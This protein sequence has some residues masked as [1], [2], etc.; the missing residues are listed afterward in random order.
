MQYD[1]HAIEPAILKRWQAEG[2]YAKVKAKTQ[3][4]KPFYFLD[5][6]PYA[7]GKVH[8][9]TAWNKSLKDAVLRYK[10]MQGFN[11]WDR[12]GY[13]MHGLP[14]ENAAMKKLGLKDN[15]DI[16]KL[17]INTFLEECRKFAIENMH[18]MNE[19]FMRLGVWMDFENAYQ[20][21]TKEFMEAEWWLIKQAHEKGR[22]YEGL[23]TMTWCANAESSL[24]KHELEYKT[25]TDESI[26]VKF[27]IADTDNEYL[28][29][30]TTTPW[31][32]PF[33]LA[34][35]VNPEVEY[36]KA[37]VD[38]E[39]WIVASPLAGVFIQ[40][41]ANKK[42]TIKETFTGDK[43]EGV[44]YIHPF[45]DVLKEEYDAIGEHAKK[46]HTILLS[47]EYVDT[48]AGSGL[49]HCAPGC[50]PEDYE[51]GHRNGLPAYNTIDTKGVFPDSMHEF[52]GLKAKKD[53]KKFIEALE[54]RGALV[55]TTDVEHEYPHDWRYH[56]PVIF[57][58]T[59]QWFFKVEDLKEQMVKANDGITWVPQAAYNAFDSWLKN[60]RDNSISKQ[61]YWGTPLPVWRNEDNPDD[62]IVIGS[63]KELE[64]LSGKKVDDLHISTV[65]T[66]T[67]TKDGKNYKRIPDVLDVWVDAGTVSWN[68][69]DYPQ[70]TDLFENLFPADFILEGKDQIRGWF[71][72]LMVASTLAFD[73]P[74]F[75]NVYMHGFINDAQGRKMSKSLG[76]YI[77]PQ[78]VIDKYGADTFRYYMI[79]AANPG[80]DC[81]YNMDDVDLKHR[82][83]FVFWNIQNFIIQMAQQLDVDLSAIKP[84]DIGD[85]ERYILSLLHATIRDATAAF[86]AYHINEIPGMIERLLLGLSR[87][88]IQLIREKASSGT[89]QEQETVLAT[90]YTVFTQAIT[91]FAPI[92]PFVSEQMHENLRSVSMAL[93]ESIH[94]E[95][96]PTH[97][98]A[99]IDDALITSMESAL[100]IIQQVLAAREKAKLTVRWPIKS[101]VVDIARDP[102]H[103]AVVEQL[104]DLICRQTNAKSIKTVEWF[105]KVTY[106]LAPN[107]KELGEAF[108]QKTGAIGGALKQ[109]DA[110]QA[111]AIAKALLK[112]GKASTTL[113]GAKV[114]LKATHAAVEIVPQGPFIGA[115]M[116]YIDTTRDDKLDNEGFARELMRRIQSLRKDA[117]LDK[118][119]A[120]ALTMK[121]S[122]RLEKGLE[123][124]HKAIKERCGVVEIAMGEPTDSHHVNGS[125][126]GE[127]FS[128][129]I[130][131]SS[132]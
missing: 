57:R 56:E 23:R 49:V 102:T 108:G 81:N 3:K 42:Y 27:K 109:L 132:S 14:V 130:T 37:Q 9:G 122:P 2:T 43:L 94:L 116:V 72:L 99:L 4:G 55:A 129:G 79:G 119:D 60:L 103:K 41:V 52:A 38:D 11:V 89:R 44:K 110:P 62:Y 93:S 96:W 46:L 34:V 25:V 5:G 80:I 35:M 36:I 92:A 123:E 84:K 6:P 20:S 17:G 121:L 16:A 29:I 88:Y 54:Q 65:D 21:I 98:D 68:C 124:W 77:L 8:L 118:G 127:E 22:L 101:I 97:D 58:T 40:S 78:E 120:V 53:D 76:N 32:I 91:M 87:T 64:E 73:K 107:F 114:D 106:S 115:E 82:N 69:L 24:A 67:I 113:A 128:I 83:L 75:K 100:D 85:E 33:N 45:S 125:I 28:I 7:N 126:K 59:K 1:P 19:D 12:A 30:W 61:R 74:S 48:S 26:F 117:G 111:K 71:N 50:G 86:D 10:R 90:I 70:R 112:E 51:V 131:P 39:V 47:S 105:D 63:A 15:E 104:G 66:I 95:D 13:D 18:V 31:T